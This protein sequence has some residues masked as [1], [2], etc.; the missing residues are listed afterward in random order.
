MLVL[1][2]LQCLMKKSKYFITENVLGGFEHSRI[3]VL[4]GENNWSQQ[5]KCHFNP[6]FAPLRYFIGY[7]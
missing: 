2:A 3:K 1:L 5:K 6:V 7:F 4:V